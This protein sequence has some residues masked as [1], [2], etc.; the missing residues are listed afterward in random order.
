ML[1]NFNLLVLV[2]ILLLAVP[3]R[4]LRPMLA[5]FLIGGSLVTFR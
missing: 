2:G 5:S 4:W 3:T 1:I